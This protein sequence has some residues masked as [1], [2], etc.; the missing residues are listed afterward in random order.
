MGVIIL[1]IKNRKKLIKYL[2][3][4]IDE[5][6]GMLFQNR[7]DVLIDFKLERKD[8]HREDPYVL[9]H[10]HIAYSLN[11]DKIYEFYKDDK[12]VINLMDQTRFI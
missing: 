11:P 1:N 9:I 6:A 3:Q 2:T 8:Y 12:E 4:N 5:H 7:S 10:N